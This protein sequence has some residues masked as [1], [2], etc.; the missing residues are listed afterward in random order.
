M[1]RDRLGNAAGMTFVLVGSFS[2]AEVKPLVAR[3]LGGLPSS[4]REAHFRDVGV[5]YPPGNIDRTL[6]KGSD[7]SAVT[8]IYSGVHPYSVG[9]A[10]KLE[11]LAEVLRL[12]VVDRI[13]E[14]LGTSY[15]PGVVSQFTNVPVGEYELRFWVACSPDEAP[16]VGRTIDG[17]IRAVQENGPTAAE[18]AKVTRTWLNEHDARTKTNQV[19]GPAASELVRWIR[20]WTR[21]RTTSPA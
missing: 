21:S 1:F 3:Y 12:R 4:P 14:E 17:I 9:A 6:Q 18:L 15:S 13:R 2:I 8:V 16:S 10:L 5:R 19:P 20:P 11:A 7:N